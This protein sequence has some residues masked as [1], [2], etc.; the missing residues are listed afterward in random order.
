MLR[1]S[2]DESLLELFKTTMD[3]KGLT[4]KVTKQSMTKKLRL[5]Y[6]LVMVEN[7]QN[8]PKRS[9]CSKKAGRSAQTKVMTP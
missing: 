8:T 3:F 6:F 2:S 4:F 1:E 7:V 5:V 9:R